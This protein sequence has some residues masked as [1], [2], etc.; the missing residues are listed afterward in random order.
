[1]ESTRTTAG[2]TSPYDIGASLQCAT[3]KVN[4]AE[5]TSGDT[6]VSPPTTSLPSNRRP[7]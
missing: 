5:R 1:M 3:V 7:G 4:R 6:P 2:E